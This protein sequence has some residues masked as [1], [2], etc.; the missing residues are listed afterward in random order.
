MAE[1]KVTNIEEGS[2]LNG[3]LKS[4]CGVIVSGKI[5]GE[6][7]APTLSIATGGSVHGT[8]KVTELRS[9]GEI[10]GQIDADLIELSGRVNDQTTIKAR[11]LEVKLNATNSDKLQVAFGNCTI[12]V[13]ND[14]NGATDAAATAAK[15]QKGGGGKPK[16]GPQGD[17]P[18]A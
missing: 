12:E 14:Q 4:T 1:T 9:Q 6:V 2:E 16:G 15:D 17:G 11:S 3:T 5:K 10:S 18:A 7:Q 8:V 13:G